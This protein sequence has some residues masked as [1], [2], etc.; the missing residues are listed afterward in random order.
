MT[1]SVAFNAVIL[2][3]GRGQRL[4]VKSKPMCVVSGKTLLDRAVQSVQGAVSVVVAGPVVPLAGTS[5][6]VFVREDPPFGGPVAGLQ[7]AWSAATLPA[8]WTLIL[9]CDVP[10]AKEGVQ[11]LLSAATSTAERHESESGAVQSEV[12]SGFS[13]VDEEGFVQWLF[14]LY[15]TADLGGR[16]SDACRDQ[17]MR[18]VVAGLTL[19][20]VPAPRHVTAD[21]DTPA[22]VEVWEQHLMQENVASGS[23]T[24]VRFFAAA[25]DAAGTDEMETSAATLAAV[26]DELERNR[27]P[28]FR[29]V[30]DQCAVLADG[31]RVANYQVS[32]SD[33]EVVDVLPPFCG[34]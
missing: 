5:D 24:R 13:L 4:G 23:T 16:L 15:R 28:R 27:G 18:S 25:A 7:A 20:T 10:G 31:H 34:G 17:S 22:D 6:V 8:P 9:A 1:S 11:K 29:R 2:A 12:V 33:V 26:F 14:G 3:G 30:V 32:L 19:Q 21:I